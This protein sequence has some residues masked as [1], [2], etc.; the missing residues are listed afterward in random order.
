MAANDTN[1]SDKEK[2]LGFT[3]VEA[4]PYSKDSLEASV[5]SCAAESAQAAAL[6]AA[7]TKKCADYLPAFGFLAT[8]S[9]DWSPKHLARVKLEAQPKLEIVVRGHEELGSHT[10]YVLD[11]AIWRPC[12]EFARS[13][14]RCYRRLAHLRQG[15]HDPIKEIL[16]SGYESFSS[17]P[18]AGLG[19][20]SGTTAR[21]RSWCQTLCRCIND[22]Q[23]PPLA[24]SVTLQLLAAP[25]KDVAMIALART[26]AEDDPRDLGDISNAQG[27]VTDCSQVGF[28]HRNCRAP[29]SECWQFVSG[30]KV[31]LRMQTVLK[32][33]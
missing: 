6:A 22:A 18:F 33:P 17:T 32:A 30:P 12:L 19:G 3:E 13:E 31:R 2:K 4:Q 11:C 20:R 21:L 8:S 16:G 28:L 27:S 5:R 26:C 9:V 1:V 10:W 24:V 14:W 29:R 15:L 25:T 7:N 23:A